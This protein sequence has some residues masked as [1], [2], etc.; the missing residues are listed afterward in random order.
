M[1]WSDV[2]PIVR[3]AF[4][5]EVERGVFKLGGKMDTKPVRFDT[6]STEE[7]FGI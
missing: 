6:T 1:K 7:V 5:Q 3:E 4:S 2:N